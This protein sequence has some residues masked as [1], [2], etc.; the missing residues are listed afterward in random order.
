VRATQLWPSAGQDTRPLLAQ[1]LRELR[2][3]QNSLPV[4]TICSTDPTSHPRRCSF[5]RRSGS[6]RSPTAVLVH[7][8][9]AALWQ[10]D[11]RFHGST[12]SQPFGSQTMLTPAYVHGRLHGADAAGDGRYC[13]RRNPAVVVEIFTTLARGRTQRRADATRRVTSRRG[14][15]HA[16]PSPPRCSS[17]ASGASGSRGQVQSRRQPRQRSLPHRW[18][19]PRA[20]HSW[21]GLCGAG[22]RALPRR[23][24]ARR[25]RDARRRRGPRRARSRRRS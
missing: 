25:F 16:R 20:Q 22:P 6:R 2:A 18:T 7:P 12:N 11:G 10:T 4:R 9:S 1:A 17:R 21:S 5:A 24:P 23:A 3:T 19:A 15:S 13:I 8:R 14:D